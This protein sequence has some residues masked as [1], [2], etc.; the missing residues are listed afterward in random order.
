MP[1]KDKI[2]TILPLRGKKFKKKPKKLNWRI[3]EGGV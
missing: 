2:K 1:G 3:N